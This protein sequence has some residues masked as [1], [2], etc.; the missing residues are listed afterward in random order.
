MQPEFR[1]KNFFRK[2]R[3]QTVMMNYVVHHATLT[4]QKQIIKITEEMDTLITFYLLLLT[5]FQFNKVSKSRM[6]R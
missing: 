3:I 1:I 2:M 4:R 6:G 5:Y